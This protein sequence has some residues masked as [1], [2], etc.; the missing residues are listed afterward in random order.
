M[1]SLVFYGFR[2]RSDDVMYDCLPLYHAAGNVCHTEPG[3]LGLILPSAKPRAWDGGCCG[4]D[5]HVKEDE[6]AACSVGL[7]L[8]LLFSLEAKNLSG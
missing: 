7:R 2:M 5:L 8:F 4:C 3:I 1:S 6:T